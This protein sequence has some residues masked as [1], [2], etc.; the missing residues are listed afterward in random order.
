MESNW[1]KDTLLQDLSDPKMLKIA[2][3]L[4]T[5]GVNLD[6]IINP[7]RVEAQKNVQVQAQR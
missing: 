1:D 2:K 7:D 3:H 5:K 4:R 6:K